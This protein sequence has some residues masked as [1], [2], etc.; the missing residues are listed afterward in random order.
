VSVTDDRVPAAALLRH[1]AFICFEASR[2]FQ[3]LGMQM[4]SVAVGWQ[5][6]DLTRDPLD[7]GYVG[8]TQFLPGILLALVA[9]HTADRFD[10]RRIVQ[11]CLLV[12][13]VCAGLFAWQARSAAPSVRAIYA[14]LVLLGV[15]RA[16]S[17]PASQS[18]LPLLVPAEAFGSAVGWHLM[19][20]QAGMAAGPALGGV[21]YA[22]AGAPAA[23]AGAG[24]L[25]VTA[26]VCLLAVRARGGVRGAA[27]MTS[28]SLLAGVR[29]VWRHRVILGAVSLD[30]F[31]VLLGGAVALLPAVARDILH[32]GPWGLG[33]LRGAPAV[34]AGLAALYLAL[35]PLRRRAGPALL[36]F[37]AVFG[38][39]TVV[40]ALSR[41]FMLSVA[42]L[43][44]VGAA[45]MVSVAVRHTLIQ[46]TTPDAMRG[47]VTAVSMV[48]IGA[49]NELGE[50]ESGLTAAWWG[51]AR[52]IWVGGLSACGVVALW[53]W[54]FPELRR[55]DRIEATR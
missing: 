23:Y 42:A 18:M 39:A 43:V 32:T 30:L 50:F 12:L 20:F 53:A 31:A 16:F 28:E 19:V 55:V 33:V 34:G 49:S 6:Y 54:L 14:V 5:I 8:L 37:V 4:L 11:M 21:V 48:F 9:G 3:V 13:V 46:L 35:R 15:A 44:V 40:F 36:G 1:P 51:T 25:Y 26:F 27:E 7:L 10:R 52:A 29:Y 24:G 41:S 17:G 2:L 38:L 45:D 22:W 47:R